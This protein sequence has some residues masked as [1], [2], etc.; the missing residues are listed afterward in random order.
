MTKTNKT[1]TNKDIEAIVAT[2]VAAL[3]ATTPKA[4]GF[5]IYKTQNTSS[6]YFFSDHQPV[7]GIDLFGHS[8]KDI[9]RMVREAYKY[10]TFTD[11]LQD[12]VNLVADDSM[13]LINDTVKTLGIYDVAKDKA[14][15]VMALSHDPDL[16]LD[17]DD[18]D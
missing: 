12:L 8:T 15:F 17:D 11:A 13:E 16:D 2:V 18:E 4:K 6:Q 7:D 14:V 3:G 9:K 5:I 10:D 1:L